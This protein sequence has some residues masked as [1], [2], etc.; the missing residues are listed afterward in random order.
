MYAECA[1]ETRAMVQS[2]MQEREKL[3][4]ENSS[5]ATNAA[6]A[7]ASSSEGGR[8]GDPVAALH[9]ELRNV[10]QENQRLQRELEH[11]YAE[12]D[13]LSARL[14]ATKQQP[15]QGNTTNINGEFQEDEH[16]EQGS[17]QRMDL[18][19]Q[20]Y[21]NVTHA[22]RVGEDNE[23]NPLSALASQVQQISQHAKHVQLMS[24]KGLRMSTESKLKHRSESSPASYPADTIDTTNEEEA[25]ANVTEGEGDAQSISQAE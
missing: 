15:S 1:A 18:D 24:E 23:E 19:T 6:A 9:A 5:N 4:A 8:S 2:Q 7:A 16:P 3:Q 22:D 10:Q 20:S 21:A 11:V 14:H 17:A 25:E 13:A 12:R